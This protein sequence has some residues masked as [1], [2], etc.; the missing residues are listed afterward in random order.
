[1]RILLIIF[2][3]IVA[4]IGVKWMTRP[5]LTHFEPWEFRAWW[6]F[7][8]RDLLLKLDHFRKLWDDEVA[9]SKAEGAIGR[10][11]GEDKSRHNLD[12]WG[13]VQA[14]DI[15]PKGMITAEDRRRAVKIAHEV[16]FMGI[17]VYPEWSPSAGL[18]VDVRNTAAVATWSRMA[19]NGEQQY[20]GIEA[21][22]V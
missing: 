1:M 20:L 15:L 13:E 5:T 4:I 6:P 11:G 14:I 8:S 3:L 10:H 16:G 19:V 22:L 12:L 7:M 17:G 21:G 2:G 18:H 9:I